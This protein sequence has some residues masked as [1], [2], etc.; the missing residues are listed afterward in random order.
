[1]LSDMLYK[2]DFVVSG[3]TTEDVNAVLMNGFY[4]LY[5]PINDYV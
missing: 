5:G 1:M 3:I 4:W 2:M